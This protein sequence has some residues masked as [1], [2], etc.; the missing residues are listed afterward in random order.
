M[1]NVWS[2]LFS[3]RFA[4]SRRWQPDCTK[5]PVAALDSAY[6]DPQGYTRAFNLKLLTR[7]NRELG[8]DFDE[9]RFRHKAYYNEQLGRVEMHLVS[10]VEQQVR[11]G[12]HTVRFQPGETIHTESSWKYT[13]DRFQELAAKAGFGVQRFFT[14]ERGWF[15]VFVLSVN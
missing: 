6:N 9:R 11:I 2:A 10:V 3:E 1:W 12:E 14:D 5:Q 15:G 13:R 8:A 7:L 4:T